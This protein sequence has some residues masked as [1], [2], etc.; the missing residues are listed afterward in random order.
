MATYPKYDHRLDCILIN[1]TKCLGLYL[2][3]KP[4]HFVLNSCVL[5]CSFHVEHWFI[6][7][8]HHHPHD[9][10]PAQL[11]PTSFIILGLKVSLL[12]NNNLSYQNHLA[13]VRFTPNPWRLRGVGVD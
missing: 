9:C 13:F 7:Y 10:H 12:I 8:D 6:L 3:L 11:K 4:L 1:K 5:L 2:C